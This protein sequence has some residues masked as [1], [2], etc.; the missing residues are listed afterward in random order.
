MRASLADVT[1]AID[2]LTAEAPPCASNAAA[3]GALVRALGW[4][5]TEYIAALRVS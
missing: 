5:W 3:I 4:T 2:A 1:A